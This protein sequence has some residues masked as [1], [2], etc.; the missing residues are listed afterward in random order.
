MVTLDII[1]FYWSCMKKGSMCNHQSSQ[2]WNDLEVAID[3]RIEH[4]RIVLY[5]FCTSQHWILHVKY[6][7]LC[8]NWRSK[9]P[10]DL[11]EDL[12]HILHVPWSI[13]GSLSPLS[14]GKVQIKSE[15]VFI[16]HLFYHFT[17]L[18]AFELF[19]HIIFGAVLEVYQKCE[20]FLSKCFK[21]E[22]LT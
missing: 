14:P 4:S 2:G 12:E 5:P 22:F 15:T 3:S 11:I 21:R 1:C 13:F 20:V 16:S 8:R 10:K 6:Q 18:L 17:T 7:V 9:D 19:W